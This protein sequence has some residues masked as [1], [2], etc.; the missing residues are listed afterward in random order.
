MRMMS[1]S[2]VRG[3]LLI[4]TVGMFWANLLHSFSPWDQAGQEAQEEPS[5]ANSL[6]VELTTEKEVYK[7][8]EPIMVTVTLRNASRDKVF[9]VGKSRSITRWPGA[10]MLD[11]YDVEG[12]RL[13]DKIPFVDAVPSPEDIDL[14]DMILKARGLWGP[15]AFLGFTRSLK[16]CGYTIRK[17]GRYR[18]KASYGDHGLADIADANQI[19][20]AKKHDE[21]WI[22]KIP[23]WSGEIESASVWIRIVP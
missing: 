13:P 5:T 11:V 8:G 9:W 7:L 6:V 12:V 23:L 19:E 10:F 2:G 15:G 18:L 22:L 14:V 16:S 1:L 17:P 3:A 21:G 20:A 4:L